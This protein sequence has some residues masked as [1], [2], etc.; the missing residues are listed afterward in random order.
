MLDTV[1]LIGI[2]YGSPSMRR[3]WIE[4]TGT[5]NDGFMM[6]SPS[7]RR[8]WIEMPPFHIQQ[9]PAFRLPPYGGSGLKLRLAALKSSRTRLPPCGGSGLKY[10]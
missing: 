7:M 1:K 6:M 2:E 4:M 5:K 3:E 10:C 8:E 9:T